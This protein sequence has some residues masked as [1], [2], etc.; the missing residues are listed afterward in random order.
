MTSV[1]Q[2]THQK[3]FHVRRPKVETYTEDL[4]YTTMGQTLFL[5]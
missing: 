3:Y 1:G 2:S 5:S 4:F